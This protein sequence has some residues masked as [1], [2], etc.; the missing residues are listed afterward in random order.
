MTAPF[1]AVVSVTGTSLRRQDVRCLFRVTTKSAYR[2]VTSE[3][4]C[5]DHIQAHPTPAIRKP[6]SGR[7]PCSRPGQT[8][9]WWDHQ[10][11]PW[12]SPVAVTAA[13]AGGTTR[14]APDTANP[15][16]AGI[17]ADQRRKPT[18][19]GL[20]TIDLLATATDAQ[21]PVNLSP[22]TFEVLRAQAWLQVNQDATRT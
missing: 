16:V 2:Q 1:S 17:R 20:P 15:H 7:R 5:H 19:A 22:A 13:R 12:Q 18:G 21:R 6:P 9:G 8:P 4:D 3:P 11:R 10:R 14:C